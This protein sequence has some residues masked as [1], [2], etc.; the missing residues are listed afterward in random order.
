MNARIRILILFGIMLIVGVI[1]VA[2]FG[3]PTWNKWIYIFQEYHFSRKGECIITEDEGDQYCWLYTD[4]IRP[5]N[6]NGIWKVWSPDGRLITKMHLQE[7]AVD[8]M[9][10]YRPDGQ[11]RTQIDWAAQ[12]KE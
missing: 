12:E 3:N 2:R 5:K 6:Y 8:R 10:E 9:V 4:N 1:V 7:G 11:M